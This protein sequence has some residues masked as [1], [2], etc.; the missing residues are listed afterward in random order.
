[1]ELGYRGPSAD[2]FSQ[3]LSL[4]NTPPSPPKIVGD[5]AFCYNPFDA[6]ATVCSSRGGHAFSTSFISAFP[7]RRLVKAKSKCKRQGNS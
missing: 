4:C 7:A 1:M 5:P 6:F 2:H 3:R